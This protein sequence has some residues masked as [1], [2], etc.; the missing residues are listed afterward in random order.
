MNSTITPT[1]IRRSAVQINFQPLDNVA[2]SY[3]PIG[4]RWTFGVRADAEFS[5][6]DL[7]FY[8]RPYVTLCPKCPAMRYQRQNMTQVEMEVRWQ[9]WKRISAVG[10]GGTAVA[11]NSDNRLRRSVAVG[12]GGVGVRYEL[13]RCWADL[14]ESTLL[15]DRKTPAIYFEFGSA[16]SRP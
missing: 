2:I 11:W 12:A 13:A 6:T 5:F 14:S 4:S 16:W 1:L 8:A 3:V 7:I 10:F 9:F 15:A